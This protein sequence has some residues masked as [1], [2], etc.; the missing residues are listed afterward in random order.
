MY[1]DAFRPRQNKVETSDNQEPVVSTNRRPEQENSVQEASP[2]TATASS[3]TTSE[4]GLSPKG[5]DLET[6]QSSDNKLVH[7]DGVITKDHGDRNEFIDAADNQ[8]VMENQT[9]SFGDNKNDMLSKSDLPT[10]LDS[11]KEESLVKVKEEVK[12]LESKSE[13]GNE[14][15]LSNQHFEEIK[16]HVETINTPFDKQKGT[17]EAVVEEKMSSSAVGA[18]GENQEDVKEAFEKES[19]HITE[20]SSNVSKSTEAVI[21]PLKTKSIDDNQQKNEDVVD[22]LNDNQNTQENILMTDDHT[23]TVTTDTLSKDN[24]VGL[25]TSTHISTEKSTPKINESIAAKV[26]VKE[27][28]DKNHTDGQSKESPLIE[29]QTSEKTETGSKDIEI[30]DT[31]TIEKQDIETELGGEQLIEKTED[32]KTIDNIKTTEIQTIE[33]KGNE[34][35]EAHSNDKSNEVASTGTTDVQAK[36]ETE[37]EIHKVKDDNSKFLKVADIDKIETQSKEDQ[38]SENIITDIS[39]VTSTEG[40]SIE[41]TDEIL[42]VDKLV[43]E[44]NLVESEGKTAEV[45]NVE[46]TDVKTKTDEKYEERKMEKTEDK[47]L[48]TK[49]ESEATEETAKNKIDTATVELSPTKEKPQITDTLNSFTKSEGHI[50][51]LFDDTLKKADGSERNGSETVVNDVLNLVELTADNQTDISREVTLEKDQGTSDEA[52]KD[53]DE[54]KVD[55]VYS[56]SEEKK[57][58]VDTSLSQ[59]EQHE[60]VPASSLQEP[61]EDKTISAPKQEQNLNETFHVTKDETDTLIKQDDLNMDQNTMDD[62]LP[63]QEQNL[64][65]TLHVTKDETDT[66]IKQDDLNK[67]QNVVDDALHKQEQNLS[68]TLHVAKDETDTLI[69]Q[70][71]SNKDQN[72]VDNVQRESHIIPLPKEPEQSVANDLQT[73]D[74]L[75][76]GTVNG[77]SEIHDIYTVEDTSTSTNQTLSVVSDQKKVHS[78]VI[79]DDTITNGKHKIE[80]EKLVD[81]KSDWTESNDDNNLQVKADKH[82]PTI[83]TSVEYGSEKGNANSKQDIQSLKETEIIQAS[84]GLVGT[85][86]IVESKHTDQTSEDIPKTEN[87]IEDVKPA[88][89]KESLTKD[90]KVPTPVENGEIE[91]PTEET[92]KEVPGTS[93]GDGMLA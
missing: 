37:E 85:Q 91:S 83:N 60:H 46:T 21:S 2:D 8:I 71:D 36:G 33:D 42:R 24:V 40:N 23:D 16:E 43:E 61:K 49:V 73:G 67:D 86:S 80:D 50:Q 77:H 10:K 69:K 1:R 27:V 65:E 26:E 57:A 92:S 14:N 19:R 7:G 13:K 48:E 58:T 4:P 47:V 12:K 72:V 82:T 70:D 25:E 52:F 88:S 76:S 20:T 55:K 54:S 15:E 9:K 11:P 39:N 68:E 51:E 74:T 41:G 28:V 31:K 90:T 45:D 22:A 78:L 56:V 87:V 3:V 29:E 89:A 81:K 17:Q 84:D 64:S 34:Q 59:K 62:A 63:K 79:A 32:I 5:D 44:H 66:L 93:D 6:I 75:R 53:T 38:L 30:Y 18:E 35:K